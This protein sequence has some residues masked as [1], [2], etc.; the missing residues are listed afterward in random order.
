MTSQKLAYVV[1]LAL[2]VTWLVLFSLAAREP[3]APLSRPLD[4]IPDE[5]DGWTVGSAN[6]LDARAERKLAA[7]GYI[8][9]TYVREGEKIEL[10][11]AYYPVQRP[12]SAAHSPQNCLPGAGWEITDFGKANALFQGRSVPVNRLQIQNNMDRR[13]VYYWYQTRRRI[14]ASEYLSRWFLVLDSI[15]HGD[16]STAIVRLVVAGHAGV[17]D[18]ALRFAS[19]I[20]DEVDACLRLPS[21]LP[22]VDLNSGFAGRNLDR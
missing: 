3:E 9:R 14:S 19:R 8:D 22:A 12:R 1:S 11:A 21:V 15:R 13:L 5:L 20:M 7:A 17:E 10:F 16:A 2:A 4:A 18:E 6:V